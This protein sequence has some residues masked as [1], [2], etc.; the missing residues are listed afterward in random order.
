MSY[1]ERIQADYC[2]VGLTVGSHPMRLVRRQLP[3][4][5]RAKDLGKGKN[6]QQLE[7]AGEVI[8]RQRPGTAK[9]FVFVSLEDETGIINMVL[10]A[11]F[12]DQHRLVVKQEPFLR[13]R[14][15]LQNIDNV[16]HVKAEAVSRLYVDGLPEGRS[17]D[18]H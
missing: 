10:T 3:E 8:C 12:F 5:W 9:G 16:V 11:E 17:H 14:G 15:R 6:G 18:F 7:V 4:L 1:L 2:A 13:F